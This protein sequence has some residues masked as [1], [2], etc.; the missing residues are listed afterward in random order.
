MAAACWL[1]AP[2]NTKEDMGLT[3]IEA[4][5]LGVPAIV[6]RDGGLPEA[7]GPAALLCEPGNVAD[8]RHALEV[9]AG[10]GEE[11]YG[12]RSHEAKSS[13]QQYLRPMGDYLRIY[14]ELLPGAQ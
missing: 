5:H 7:G 8:L 12:R 1:V 13:L 2:A 14:G 4:R 9:A 11:E 6:T 10:M 3:P